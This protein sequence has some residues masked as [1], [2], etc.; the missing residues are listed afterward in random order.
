MRF[1][2]ASAL[3]FLHERIFLRAEFDAKGRAREVELFAEEA[4]EIAA[5]IFP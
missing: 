5:A 3:F 4:L 1:E 2:D